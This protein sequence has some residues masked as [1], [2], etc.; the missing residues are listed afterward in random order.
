MAQPAASLH[1]QQLVELLAVVSSF[2]DEASAVQGAAERAAQTMEAEVAAVVVDGQVLAAVGFPDDQLPYDDLVAVTRRERSDIEVPGF[3][4]CRA[5]A[6]SSGGPNPGYLVLARYDGEFSVEERNLVRGMARLLDLTLTMLRTLHAEHA[7]RE[8]S[9]RQAAE[10]AQLLESLRQRQRLLGHLFD[11]QRSISRRQ[12]LPQTLEAITGAARDLLGA[13]LAGLWLRDPDD[14]GRARL[15]SQVGLAEDRAKRLP[16]MRLIDAGAAGT[17][18]LTDSLVARHGEAETSPLISNLTDAHVYAVLAAPVH[19]SGEVTGSLLVASCQPGRRYTAADEQTLQA[20]AG[21]VSLALTDANTVDRMHQAFHDSL[22][23]LASR[24]LFLERLAQQLTAAE[25]DRSIVAVLFIDLDRFKEIND[26]LGHE[27]GDRLLMIT[28]DRI[29]SQLRAGDVA[30]RLGGDEFAIMLPRVSGNREGIAVA[31]RIVAAMGQPMV[32]ARRE[33]RVNASIGIALSTPGRPD[34]A[35]LMRCADMAMYQA[36][37]NG[38]GRYEVFVEPM[39]SMF[40]PSL[41]PP[42]RSLQEAETA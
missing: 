30:A 27:A 6:A 21:H 13:D 42:P 4:I 36:K 11:I 40:E 1:I 12:P 5:I 25:P 28:A 38:R 19:D 34:T 37:R 8:R 3:G 20:F 31:Q 29:K 39:R 18:I 14:S 16:A 22:T 32:I 33:L 35:D 2:P 17:A 15:A 9:E 24:A 23:G 41:S 7:M 10:N 26:T